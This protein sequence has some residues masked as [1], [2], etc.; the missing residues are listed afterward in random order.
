MDAPDNIKDEVEG[1]DETILI[2]L[3]TCY[4][5]PQRFKEAMTQSDGPQW[6][7]STNL[8][9][10]NHLKNGTWEYVELPLNTKL[11]KSGTSET[12]DTIRYKNN[13]FRELISVC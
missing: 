10:N 1:Y 6:R 4:T 11:I 12:C 8:E 2:A 9:M 13:T 5:D 7:E 3:L